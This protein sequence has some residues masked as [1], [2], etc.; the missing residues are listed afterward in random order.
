MPP[1]VGTAGSPRMPGSPPDDPPEPMEDFDDAAVICGSWE[2]SERLALLF[3]RHAL[4]IARYVTRRLGPDVADDIVAETFLIAFRKR[5]RYDPAHSDARPWLYGIATNLVRRHR[6]VEVRQLR[7]LARTGADPVTESF[8]EAVDARLSARAVSRPLAAAIAALPVAQ[9]DVLLL[10]TW[11]GLTYDQAGQALG[12]PHGTVRSRM[13]RAR[14]KVREAL[15][16][17]DPTALIEEA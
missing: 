1:T 7:A 12:V 11:A 10:V 4:A 14:A 16:G 6:R 5:D 13:N 17:T 8:A 15:G 3:R 2:D 9:R